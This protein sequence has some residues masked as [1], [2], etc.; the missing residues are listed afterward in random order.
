M[1]FYIRDLDFQTIQSGAFSYNPCWRRC[2]SLLQ[3]LFVDQC[4]YIVF[5][6]S[7]FTAWTIYSIFSS[8]ETAYTKFIHHHHHPLDNNTMLCGFRCLAILT[9]RSSTL[10]KFHTPFSSQGVAHKPAPVNE[11]GARTHGTRELQY[12]SAHMKRHT[13]MTGS[14]SEWPRFASG[15]NVRNA[16]FY[17]PRMFNWG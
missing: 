3:H 15:V 10:A 12:I 1:S 13:M 5:P 14:C 4:L 17:F 9:V 16:T 6:E 2:K 11:S 8:N 7:V